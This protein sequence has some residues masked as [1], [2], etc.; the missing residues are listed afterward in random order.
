MCGRFNIAIAVG[1]PERFEVPEPSPRIEL[2]Y[3][4]APTQ[5]VPIIVRESPNRI[6]MKQWG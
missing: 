3:N 4:I 6:Q 2:H 5:I 1:W